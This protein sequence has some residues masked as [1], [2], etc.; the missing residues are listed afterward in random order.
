MPTPTPTRSFVGRWLRRA[1][2]LRRLPGTDRALLAKAWLTLAFA[3]LGVRVLG[4]PR[5]QRL[6]GTGRGPARDIPGD[7]ARVRRVH[8]AVVLVAG[9]HLAAMECLPQSLASQALLRREGIATE[10]HLGVRPQAATVE[11]H[12]WITHHGVP[13]GQDRDLHEAWLPLYSDR[14]GA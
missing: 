5:T 9:R 12:A 11:A 10:L 1:G 7:A 3:Q 6:L 13:I 2:H 8:G 4:L 14:E